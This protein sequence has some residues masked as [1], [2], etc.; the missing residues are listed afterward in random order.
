[1]A[2]SGK[3]AQREVRRNALQRRDEQWKKINDEYKLGRQE[4]VG[5]V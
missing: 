5:T 3:K 4:Y 2:K 1:M